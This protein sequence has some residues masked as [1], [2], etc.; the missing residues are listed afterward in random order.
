MPKILIIDDDENIR[1]FLEDVL[2]MSGF[3]VATASDGAEGVKKA[4][5]LLPEILI[6]DIVMPEKEGIEVIMEIRKQHP[7]IKI[8]AMS[9]GTE[10]ASLY[11]DMAEKL[12]ARRI[13]PKPFTHNDI[14]LAVKELL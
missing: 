1:D 3:E 12:G 10:H 6:T 14:L 11:L 2:S 8:I 7:E 13:L 5:E 4:K 9:G